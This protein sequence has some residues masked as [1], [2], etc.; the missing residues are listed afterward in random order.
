MSNSF[1]SLTKL[2]FFIFSL[3]IF[4]LISYRNH[5]E[6][7]KITEKFDTWHLHSHLGTIMSFSD[8]P[9]LA[10]SIKVQPNHRPLRVPPSDYGNLLKINK[11][12]NEL[13]F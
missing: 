2:F 1:I 8:L 6:T 12:N 3:N 7:Y 4:C 13:Y 5:I 11:I 10:R 9:D